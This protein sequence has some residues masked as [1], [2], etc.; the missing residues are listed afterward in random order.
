MS[1]AALSLPPA[2]PLEGPVHVQPGQVHLF[3]APTEA[4]AILGSCVAVC[5]W[6]PYRNVAAMNHFLL[7]TH[8]GVG[9]ESCKHGTLAM[10]TLL[11]RLREAGALPHRLRAKVFGGATIGIAVG[12]PENHL[13]TRN[14]KLALRLL[15][16]RNVPV[17]AKDVGGSRSR[18][19]LYRTASG[20]AQVQLIG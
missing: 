18:K 20:E 1:V 2:A 8:A 4:V 15:E 7:P 16:E 3:T 17:L 6:D 10:A 11:D 9:A 14:W 19:L 13:G 12:D 5:V